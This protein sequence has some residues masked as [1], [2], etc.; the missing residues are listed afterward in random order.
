[1]TRCPT[2]GGWTIGLASS[3]T[4]RGA[5]IFTERPTHTMTLTH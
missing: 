2:F 4:V 3:V 1:M 5:A